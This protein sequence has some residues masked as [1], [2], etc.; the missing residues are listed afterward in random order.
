MVGKREKVPIT[1]LKAP[2]SKAYGRTIKKFKG[3]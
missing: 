2:F 3:S 1:S